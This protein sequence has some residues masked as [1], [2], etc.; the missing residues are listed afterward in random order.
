M[1]KIYLFCALVAMAIHGYCQTGLHLFGYSSGGYAYTLDPN[2]VADSTSRFLGGGAFCR[3]TAGNFYIAD[4]G[5]NYAG[6]GYR[7]RKVDRTTHLVTTIAGTGTSGYSGDGGPAVLAQIGS[8][9]NQMAI[10]RSGNLYF[11]DGTNL[12]KI[13]TNTGIITTIA[14]LVYGLGLD[15]HNNIYYSSDRCIFKKDGISGSVSTICGSSGASGSSGDGGPAT[16]ALVSLPRAICADHNDNIYFIDYNNHKIRKIDPAGIITTFAGNGTNDINS[17]DG[18]LA[19]NGAIRPAAYTLFPDT[20][21]NIY[22]VQSSYMGQPS[23]IRKINAQTGRINKYADINWGALNNYYV[24]GDTGELYFLNYSHGMYM[25][26]PQ[27]TINLERLTMSD[28]LLTPDCTLPVKQYGLTGIF[29]GVPPAGDSVHLNIAYSDSSYNISLPYT[30]S[31][32]SSG[33]TVYGFTWSDT[34]GFRY[35][36]GAI[37]TVT[38]TSMGGYHDVILFTPFTARTACSSSMYM[39]RITSI[40]D[41]VLTAPCVF[42]ANVRRTI[43]GSVFGNFL[44]NDSVYVSVNN[45]DATI[46]TFKV[47]LSNNNAFA[48]PNWM[49]WDPED[50]AWHSTHPDSVYRWTVTYDHIYAPRYVDPAYP[51]DYSSGY[52]CLVNASLNNGV[53]IVQNDIINSYLEPVNNDSFYA[54]QLPDV[55]STTHIPPCDSSVAAINVSVDD[56]S[57]SCHNTIPFLGNINITGFLTGAVSSVSSLPIYINFGDGSDT[58]ITVTD[59]SSPLTGVYQF[60][61]PLFHHLYTLPGNY[62]ISAVADSSL[63]H[64]QLTSNEIDLANSCAPLTGTFFIDANNNCTADSGETRLGYWP[65]EVIN[66]TTGDT[67]NAWCDNNG[68]YR[69]NLYDGNTYTIVNTHSSYMGG[70]SLAM[71][72]PSS[73]VYSVTAAAGSSFTQ[74]FGFQCFNTGDVDMAVSAWGWGFVPGDTGVLS[75]WS[76]NEWGYMCDSLSSTVTLVKDHRLTYAGMWNGPVPT[77]ISGDT[78]TWVFATTNNLLDFTASIKVVCDTTATIFDTVHNAVYVTPTLATDVNLANNTYS[79][80]EPVRTSWDPNEKEVS[81]RGYGSEGYIENGTALSYM[82]HFQNTGTAQA[83]NITVVDSLSQDLDMATLQVINSSSAVEV[84]QAEGNVVRFRFNDI[85]LPDSISDPEGSIGFISFNILPKENLAPGT[86]ITNRVGIYFDYNPAVYT[87]AT[88]NTIEDTVRAITGPDQVCV[89]AT[90]TLANALAGGVWSAANGNATVADGVVTGVH[91]GVD[92]IAYTMYGNK[93]SYA[94]VTILTVPAAATISGAADVCVAAAT[95][96]TPS[97]AGGT[98]TSSSSAATVTGGVVSGI[99]EGT[100]TISYAITNT[101]GSSVDTIT[102]TIHAMPDAGTITGASSV[103]VS[104]AITLANAVTGGTWSSSSSVATVADGVVTAVSAGS[105]IISYSVSNMCG[106]TTDT[107][108]IAINNIADAGTI[109]GLSALCTTQSTTLTSSVVGGSWSTAN[110]VVSVTSG[111]EITAATVGTDTVMYIVTSACGTDTAVQVINVAA[112]PVAGTITGSDSLCEGAAMV[113][114]ESEGGGVWT[115]SDPTIASINASGVVSAV[116][117]GMVTINYAVTNTCGTVSATHNLYIV[118]AADC[119]TGVATTSGSGQTTIYPNPSYGDIVV[120]LPV[121]DKDAVITI[122]DITGKTVKELHPSS[123]G[124][125]IQV[126]VNELAKGTYLFTVNSKGTIY[127]EKIVLW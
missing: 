119:N 21:G 27:H 31:L 45:D 117:S 28:T 41:S 35:V 18:V 66:N 23:E 44:Q 84:Y 105:A 122:T 100:A 32:D 86:Q 2:G 59:I 104:S 26:P 51:L 106:T 99:A 95:T 63:T 15:Q 43:R 69:L 57:L 90:I 101:C 74:N 118:S 19:V 111:G 24:P 88:I 79:W 54:F 114:T 12:R 49:A 36:G 89:G 102:M 17:A 91:E 11:I 96:L 47:A 78:L 94:I 73:G 72:C 6:Q 124:T 13:N 34:H 97:V 50:T 123:T 82:I 14:S 83:R 61:I 46:S 3:D 113:L 125:V 33:N 5:P 16:S 56:S 25:V 40:H 55:F 53:Y 39:V 10:D 109:T 108:L 9:I 52:N 98:W 38:V 93:V 68:N 20:T 29:N 115:S 110:G 80:S 77:V 87:N 22:F 76:S 126:S 48:D 60:N 67:I 64:T 37:A 127:R 107:M 103:C 8:S 116:G 1:R 42:P 120:E 71:T 4:I 70:D 112:M 92:T 75:V 81:P 85:N 65:F 30:T 121:A 58:T 62:T 7:I